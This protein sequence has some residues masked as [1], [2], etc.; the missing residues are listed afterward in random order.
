M[1]SHAFRACVTM[2]SSIR[3]S[4]SKKVTALSLKWKKHGSAIKSGELFKQGWAYFKKDLGVF[5]F[6][7]QSLFL[8]RRKR[9]NNPLSWQMAFFKSKDNWLTFEVSHWPLV[10]PLKLAETLIPCLLSLPQPAEA[11]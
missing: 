5:T 1:R 11:A 9:N 6:L 4:Q 10:K 7:L 8:S 2:Q 3:Y